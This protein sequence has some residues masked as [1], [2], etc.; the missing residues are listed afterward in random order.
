MAGLEVRMILSWVFNLSIMCLGKLPS[1]L[2]ENTSW[3][4]SGYCLINEFR[5]D[6]SS[7]LSNFSRV[8]IIHSVAAFSSLHPLGQKF[9]IL[10]VSLPFSSNSGASMIPLLP[11]RKRVRIFKFSALFHRFMASFC[12]TDVDSPA[13]PPMMMGAIFTKPDLTLACADLYT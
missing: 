3:I 5:N 13:L 10:P 11:G 6:L 9:R 7:I 8:F 12:P 1:A 2:N 4:S